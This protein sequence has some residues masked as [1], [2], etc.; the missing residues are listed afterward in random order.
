MT[1]GAFTS[2]ARD[3]LESLGTPRLEKP[4]SEA[5]LRKMIALVMSAGDESV[6]A[7]QG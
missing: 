5:E 2:Q 1:G 4:F 3:A 7:P 6:T